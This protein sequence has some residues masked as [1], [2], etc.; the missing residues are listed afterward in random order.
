MGLRRSRADTLRESPL[1]RAL[2][3]SRLRDPLRQAAQATITPR[4]WVRGYRYGQQI[5]APET[6]EAPFAVEAAPN[7]LEAYFDA[8]S[9]G[10][11]IWKWRHYF[12]IYHRHLAQF[13]G[14]PVNIV[15][16]GI[17]SGGSLPMWREYFGPACHVYGVDIA[18]E[19]RVYED[20]GISIFIG[21]QADPEFWRTFVAQVPAIDVVIDDGGHRAYQQIATLRALLPHIRPGGVFFCEDLTGPLEPFLSFVDGL[22]RSMGTG[23]WGPPNAL[24]QHVASVHR[25]PLI[26][27][28]EKPRGSVADFEAPHHGT[29]WQPFLKA[30]R[31]IHG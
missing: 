11:G 10:P 1:G 6:T 23:R 5:A 14:Q 9:E 15:E 29:E 3:N 20:E 25:Y 17:Y 18:P 28:I 16:I 13:R 12:D 31:T 19:C 26:T 22:T 21:D 2:V 27:A 8:L 7:P 30:D 24:Q 4:D